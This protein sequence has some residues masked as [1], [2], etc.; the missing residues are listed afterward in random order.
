MI[1]AGNRLGDVDRALA[2][3]DPADLT[4]VLATI[5]Q[6]AVECSIN[7]GGHPL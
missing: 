4:E 7:A 3:V 2:P 6:F 5:E 1:T